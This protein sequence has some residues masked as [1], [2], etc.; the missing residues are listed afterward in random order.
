LNEYQQKIRLEDEIKSRREVEILEMERL[1]LDL[2]K[3]LRNTQVAQ[4]SAFEELENALHLPVTEYE[5]LYKAR[6]H[7]MQGSI[8][9]KKLQ[10]LS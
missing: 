1:E 2:L 9:K 7:K 5:N 4:K 10:S 8:K 6:E 3:K